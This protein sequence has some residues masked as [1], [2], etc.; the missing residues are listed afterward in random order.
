MCSTFRGAGLAVL[1]LVLAAMPAAAVEIQRPTPPSVAVETLKV[2]VQEIS[3][4]K[5]MP[6]VVKLVEGSVLLTEVD[7]VAYVAMLPSRGTEPMW[8]PTTRFINY[9]ADSAWTLYARRPTGPAPV[10]RFRPPNRSVTTV[11][12]L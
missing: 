9:L 5:T 7:G 2:A 11:R 4:A 6:E 12:A 3:V 1:A 10:I 8:I